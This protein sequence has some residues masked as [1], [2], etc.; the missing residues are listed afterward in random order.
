MRGTEPMENTSMLK[1]TD[2]MV[3]IPN[4]ISSELCDAIVNE[5]SDDEYDDAVV[6]SNNVE[7]D[8]RNCQTIF[9]SSAKHNGKNREVRGTIDTELFNVFNIAIIEYAKLHRNVHI[10][11]DTGYELLRYPMGGFYIEHVDSFK[12]RPRDITCSVVLNDDFDGGEFSFFNNQFS[13]KLNKGDAILFP[14]NFMYPHAVQPVTK[15]IRYAVVTWF[16][17]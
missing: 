13:Y 14:S 11:S 3:V 9:I 17:K 15:G 7:K 2:Y 5:Y 12:E 16:C 1:L 8:V 10:E 4:S 6:A